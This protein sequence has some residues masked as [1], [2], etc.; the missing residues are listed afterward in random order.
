MPVL[1]W[2]IKNGHQQSHKHHSHIH[3]C[4][5]RPLSVTASAC[6]VWGYRMINHTRYRWPR[7]GEKGRRGK[8]SSLSLLVSVF[9]FLKLWLS[10]TVVSPYRSMLT[11]STVSVVC[12]IHVCPSEI[13]CPGKASTLLA[14]MIFRFSINSKCLLSNAHRQSCFSNWN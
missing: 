5:N 3:T 2:R 6:H 9:H 13:H 4:T 11:P 12:V 14:L 8:L 7:W 1:G 10:F